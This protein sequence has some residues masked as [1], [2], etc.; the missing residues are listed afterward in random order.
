MYIILYHLMVPDYRDRST[1]T[2]FGSGEPNFT[3]LVKGGSER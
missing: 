3:R 1:I 2:F